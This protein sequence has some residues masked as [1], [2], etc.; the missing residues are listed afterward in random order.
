LSTKHECGEA[1]AFPLREGIRLIVVV[2]GFG[3]KQLKTMLVGGPLI[4][5]NNRRKEKDLRQY[6]TENSC[7]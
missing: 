5:F 2:L 1:W 7:K 3:N 6:D 4:S